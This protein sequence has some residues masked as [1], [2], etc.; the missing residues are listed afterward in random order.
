MN[1]QDDHETGTGVFHSAEFTPSHVNCERQSVDVAVRFPAWPP[2]PRRSR[3]LSGSITASPACVRNA[4]GPSG[5][6]SPHSSS[7]DR[8]T[9]TSIGPGQC[10]GPAGRQGRTES[11]GRTRR[12]LARRRPSRAGGR[13][14]E[15]GYGRRQL[16]VRASPAPSKRTTSGG[17]PSTRRLRG[18]R[19]RDASPRA[20]A[21]PRPRAPGLDSYRDL[22]CRTGFDA[23]PGAQTHLANPKRC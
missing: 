19:Q 11:F 14:A 22:Y 23:N 9:A 4:G 17:V 5:S 18:R 3:T 1:R 21:K 2:G 8:E 15:A 20:L 13:K 7:R 10:A 6:T 16:T 12:L